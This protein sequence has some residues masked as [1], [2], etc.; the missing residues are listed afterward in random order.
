MKKAGPSAGKDA[1]PAAAAQEAEEEQPEVPQ[2]GS[3]RF[4][5]INQTVYAG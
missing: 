1:G 3:G 4:E 2:E 5:Y